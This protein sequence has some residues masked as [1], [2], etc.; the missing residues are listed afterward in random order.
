MRRIDLLPGQQDGVEYGRA[1]RSTVGLNIAATNQVLTD[2]VVSGKNEDGGK[3][4]QSNT[5]GGTL[6]CIGNE[7]P[8]D[9]QFDT[10]AAIEGECTGFCYRTVTTLAYSIR[11]QGS[12]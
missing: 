12:S 8:F 3:Q 5:V 10:A 1:I 9:G 6:S 11:A 2:A 7:P 4:V